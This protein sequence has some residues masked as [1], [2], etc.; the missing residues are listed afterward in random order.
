MIGDAEPPAGLIM[1][2]E[3]PRMDAGGLQ[4]LEKEISQHN[5]LRL[6]IVDTF[7]KVKGQNKNKATTYE[8]DYDQVADLK[9]LADRA[10]IAMLVAHHLRKI[11]SEDIFDQVSGSLGLTGA[12]R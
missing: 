7:Q 4:Q 3:W 2:N 6:I 1:F 11:A 8:H 10:G 12:A 5:D 9:A